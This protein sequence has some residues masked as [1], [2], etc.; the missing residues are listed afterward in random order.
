MGSYP[1]DSSLEYETIP[2]AI[3][4]KNVFP[5]GGVIW[6]AESAAGE[7]VQDEGAGHRGDHRQGNGFV[8]VCDPQVTAPSG[9][10]TAERRLAAEQVLGKSGPGEFA[11]PKP[12]AQ[13]D[14][15]KQMKTFQGGVRVVGGSGSC[16]DNTNVVGHLSG[17]DED[18]S[19]ASD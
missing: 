10:F 3:V 19:H 8:L 13:C 18:R 2:D 14:R 5:S 11:R 15:P 4:E 9:H 6:D 16:F 7:D 12:N 1:V 17:G